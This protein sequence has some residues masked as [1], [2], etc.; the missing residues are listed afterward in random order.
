[1]NIFLSLIIWCLAS[2]AFAQ[3]RSVTFTVITADSPARPHA[4][5]H[6]NA[7]LSSK[8][9][10]EHINS[11]KIKFYS[12]P[13]KFVLKGESGLLT[14][15]SY[16]DPPT[17]KKKVCI[18]ADQTSFGALIYRNTLYVC[19]PD[20]PQQSLPVINELLAS[21]KVDSLE[22]SEAQSVALLMAKCSNTLQVYG[23]PQ[24]TSE[25]AQKRMQKMASPPSIT[26]VNGDIKVEFYS[27]S[28][29]PDS[30]I[31]KWSFTFHANRL[32]MVAR[33]EVS[34]AAQDYDPEWLHHDA[35]PHL[36]LFAHTKFTGKERDTESGLDYF[37]A[38]YYRSNMGR[39]MSPDW[40]AKAT[41][42]PYAK[43]DNPQIRRTLWY[44]SAHNQTLRNCT[45]MCMCAALAFVPSSYLA[46]PRWDVDVVD[47][48]GQPRKGAT[49]RL[50]YR[51]YSVEAESHE[52]RLQTD[53]HGRV[54]FEPQRRNA[55]LGKRLFYSASA[56]MAGVHASFGRHA[57]VLVFGNDHPARSTLNSSCT[58]GT[59]LG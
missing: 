5:N 40:A 32:L 31:S 56:A 10:S 18:E 1:M 6:I 43:L 23:D 35:A 15:F 36:A 34:K 26:T 50:V 37:G 3:T 22:E 16:T 21:A 44:E 47:R 39:F 57:Y 13:S 45:R 51:N 24:S 55:N 33:T 48:S 52:I 42:V 58:R 53:E 38:R 30:A 19:S 46:S 17:D 49:V 41:P 25:S 29:L 28:A 20:R 7:L 8:D 14:W 12:N 4:P 59:C 54:S 11:L 27:W 2:D 9:D